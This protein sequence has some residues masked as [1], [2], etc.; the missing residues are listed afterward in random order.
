M[1]W[2]VFVVFA[3]LVTTSCG[4]DG[5]KGFI[6]TDIDKQLGGEAREQYENLYSNELL[7]EKDYPELYRRM[8]AIRDRILS[9]NKLKYREEFEWDLKLIEDDKTL[10][11]FCLPAGHIYV[12]TGL[13]R[14]LDNEAQ[15]AGVIGH[16]IAHAD[17]RHAIDN[18]S[19]QLGLSL[20]VSLVFGSDG[21]QL[22]GLAQNLLGL[23]FSR[24]NEAEAD[25]YAVQYL[26]D[27]KYDA[28]EA[29][30]FF[31][32]LEEENKDEGVVEFLSTHPAPEKRF[33][34][35]LEEW[36]ALGG[37]KGETFEKEYEDLKNLLP[38]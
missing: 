11:A 31:R 27:T 13:I 3:L 5:Y 36:K 25:K 4:D 20:L 35:M 30:G 34:K 37:K 19:K 7:K 17:R 23:K 26:Y 24:G 6:S 9:S 15:L 18:M 16:E 12:Y 2:R 28:R 14:Y 22:L 8:Y 29:S 38:D 21:G 10:N 1:K 33:E 32:K